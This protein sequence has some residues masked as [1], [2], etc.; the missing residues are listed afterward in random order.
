MTWRFLPLIDPTVDRLLPR[1]SDSHISSREVTAVRQWMNDSKKTFHL[2]RDHMWHCVEI[3]GG[4]WGVKINQNRHA[5]NVQATRLFYHVDHKMEYGFDQTLLTQYIWPLAIN[6]SVRIKKKENHL[7][8]MS[9]K[10]FFLN[11][12]WHMTVIVVINFRIPAPSRL[13]D[14]GQITSPRSCIKK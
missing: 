3:L 1:D 11:D 6:D 10:H 8:V 13:K 2:M 7:Y 5:I 4:F 9:I 14:K 12:S